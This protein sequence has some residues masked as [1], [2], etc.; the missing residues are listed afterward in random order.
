MAAMN[1]LSFDAEQVSLCTAQ[2]NAFF[3]HLLNAGM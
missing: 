2:G 1:S 3:Q